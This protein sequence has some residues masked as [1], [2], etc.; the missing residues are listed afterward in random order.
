M[1]KVRTLVIATRELH[2]RHGPC[3]C[4]A[5]V[6]VRFAGEIITRNVKGTDGLTAFQCA[7]QRVSHPR[8]MLPAREK[9]ILFLEASKKNIQIT[10]KF[11][12]G[13][14]LGIKEGSEEFIVGTPAGWVVC[15]TVKR[16]PREDAADRVFF[17]SIRETPRRLLPDD[18]PREPTEPREQLLRI[19]VRPVL[20]DL[21]PPFST[22]PAK[23]RR[24]YTRN[25]G[26]LARDGYT[27]GRIGCEAAITRGPSRDHTE[28]CR[29]R[30][31]QAMSSDV[32]FSARVRDAHERMSR[33][34]SDAQPDMKKVNPRLTLFNPRFPHETNFLY[35]S[36]MVDRH[37]HQHHHLQFPLLYTCDLMTVTSTG[38][39]VSGC[40]WS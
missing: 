21:L 36:R 24:V 26:E 31:I 14:F 32:V 17:N 22:E 4:G 7:F 16:R 12:D 23:P 3:A 2:G 29:T 40:R 13:I 10:D 11:S 1:R 6:C 9:K 34:V 35:L 38:R 15:R 20:T 33:Q 18:E 25:S 27:P 8:A 37:R 28:Q 5:D 19:D 30:I 39:T